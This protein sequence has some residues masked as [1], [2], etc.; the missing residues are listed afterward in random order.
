[1]DAKKLSESWQE[2]SQE[3]STQVAM[4]RVEHPTATLAEIGQAVDEQ[5]WKPDACSRSPET[6]SANARR[7]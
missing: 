6:T 2:R 1:M 4:W 7:T 3:I 5:V